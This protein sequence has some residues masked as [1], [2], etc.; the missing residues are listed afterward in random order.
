MSSHRNPQAS[1]NWETPDSILGPIREHWGAIDFDPCT[2][3]DNPTGALNIRT[4]GCDPNGLE[5]SWS[6]FPGLAF[7]NPPYESKWYMKVWRE[8]G[9]RPQT[10]EMIALLPAKPGTRYFQK[11]VVQCDGVI[12][13]R[14]RLTFRGATMSAPFESALMYAGQSVGRFFDALGHMGWAVPVASQAL[15]SRTRKAG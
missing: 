5:T 15:T 3:R 12:F 9:S 7:V 8:L 6:E 11:L 1:P 4:A 13:I 14:G 10:N 2:T